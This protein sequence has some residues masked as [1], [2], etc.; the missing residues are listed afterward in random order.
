LFIF[1][2]PF[3]NHSKRI[4]NNFDSRPAYTQGSKKPTYICTHI[5][6]LC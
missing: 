2:V 5:H 1:R 4:V 3:E 6:I